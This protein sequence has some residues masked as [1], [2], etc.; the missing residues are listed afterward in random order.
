MTHVVHQPNSV[1]RDF[2]I[3]DIHGKY[4]ELKRLMEEKGF[5]KAHDRLFCCGD[6]VNKGP[7][8][9]KCL[10]L[11]NRNWFFPVI[12]NHEEAL[13]FAT[14]SDI[15][16]SEWESIGG[17]WLTKDELKTHEIQALLSKLCQTP[18]YITLNHSSGVKIGLCHAQ[19][20]TEDWND[21]FENNLTC[22][23]V[24][25]SIWSHSRA[26]SINFTDSFTTIQNI[27]F[28]IHGHSAFE[29]PTLL[30]NTLHID[31]GEYR[32]SS[33]PSL[34]NL[35]ESLPTILNALQPGKKTVPKI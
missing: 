15:N 7:E 20:P 29:R 9:L 5:D 10:E 14:L 21:V 26:A 32:R 33:R 31:T 23:Q 35:D 34:I 30:S 12:G 19:P 28:T 13:I 17:G 25:R 4:K 11:L 24:E 1:G 6:F 18:R 27:D 3:G 8:S 22:S 16:Y 2:V